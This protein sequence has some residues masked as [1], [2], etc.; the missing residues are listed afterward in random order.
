MPMN[1]YIKK[2]NAKQEKNEELSSE[3]YSEISM[4]PLGPSLCKHF[5]I[6]ECQFLSAHGELADYD[7]I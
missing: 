1:K 3:L 7:S 6:I 5:G 2:Q 4:M